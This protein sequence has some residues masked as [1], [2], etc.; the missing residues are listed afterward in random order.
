MARAG[1][2]YVAGCPS[3]A[4]GPQ[5]GKEQAMKVTLY[6]REDC[7]ECRQV[8]DMLAMLAA[9]EDFDL[10][11]ANSP[12]DAPAPCVRFEAPGSPFYCAEGLTE[13]GF[14]EY[15]EDARRSLDAGDEGAATR[16]ARPPRRTGAPPTAEHEAQHPVRSFLWRHR[17]GAL[18]ASLSGFLGLGWAAPLTVSFGWGNGF[19]NAVHS[20]YRLVCDQV[21][22]RSA[23]LGG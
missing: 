10:R 14:M 19:Y 11:E 7:A 20:A 23:Q 5:L 21:P 3:D 4:T 6:T 1:A 13:S 8:W 22:E 15:F 9:R 12:K 2:S 17:V 18:I 16:R